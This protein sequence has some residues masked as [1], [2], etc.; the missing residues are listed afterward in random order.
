MDRG[1]L[2]VC[3]IFRGDPNID[4]KPGSWEQSQVQTTRLDFQW[5]H[6]LMTCGFRDR[7]CEGT[8]VGGAK[9]R[10][11]PVTI[12]ARDCTG[13]SWAVALLFLAE[14]PELFYFPLSS[15]KL[16]LTMNIPS[17]KLVKPQALPQ[18][19]S[20]SPQSPLW[21]DA[22]IQLAWRRWEVTP[23]TKVS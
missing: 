6:E 1:N 21:R 20:E 9:G 4:M 23:P 3:H 7:V 16:F 18:G 5:P 10:S 14:R 13:H 11:P 12:L 19:W 22:P 2:G 17:E 15:L 8:S